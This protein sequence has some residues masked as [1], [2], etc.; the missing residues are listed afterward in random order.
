[1]ELQ[2]VFAVYFANS[3]LDFILIVGFA[4]MKYSGRVGFCA[5]DPASFV[6]KDAYGGF[7]T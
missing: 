1:M 3:I 6:D 5:V 4:S 2:C 7:G